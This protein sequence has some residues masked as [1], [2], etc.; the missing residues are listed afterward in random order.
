MKL[1]ICFYS[2]NVLLLKLLECYFSKS[3]FS[4]TFNVKSNE[5][6]ITVSINYLNIKFFVQYFKTVCFPD[7]NYSLKKNSVLIWRYQI[8]FTVTAS[9]TAFWKNAD[10]LHSSPSCAMSGRPKV[11]NPCDKSLAICYQIKQIP[12]ST[13]L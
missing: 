11:G 13:N 3:D 5:L 8:Q 7:S 12:C 2:K 1:T 4:D 6:N 9:Q 10:H